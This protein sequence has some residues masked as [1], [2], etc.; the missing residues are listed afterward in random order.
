LITG[1]RHIVS[2]I[3]FIHSFPPQQFQSHY[4]Y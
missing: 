4:D 3:H 1:Y 2:V